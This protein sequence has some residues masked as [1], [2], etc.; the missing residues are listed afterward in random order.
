[1]TTALGGL[2]RSPAQA[3][4]ARVA[5]T[6]RTRTRPGRG[7]PPEPGNDPDRRRTDHTDCRRPSDLLQ[8]RG[9]RSR[10]SH[11]WWSPRAAALVLDESGNG[12]SCRGRQN[13]CCCSARSRRSFPARG[14]DSQ[15]VRPDATGLRAA[16]PSSEAAVLARVI[17]IQLIKANQSIMPAR[18]PLKT[19]RICGIN[20]TCLNL[21]GA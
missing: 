11:R 9:S 16:V 6:A 10:G 5:A 21:C 14:P 2:V 20:K 13:G 12:W 7:H 19:I 8:R 4:N 17:T 15:S 18:A 3:R 1:M